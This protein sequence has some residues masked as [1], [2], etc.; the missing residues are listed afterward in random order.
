MVSNIILS[1]IAILS[2]STVSCNAA[3]VGNLKLAPPG[4]EAQGVCTVEEEFGYIDP[5]GLGWMAKAG[6]LTDGASIPPWAQPWVGQ[7]FKPAFIKAAV[8]HDHYCDRHVRP[9]R[10]TH[11]VFYDALLESGVSKGKAGVMYFAILVGGPKWVK[12]IK[13]KPCPFGY[14][15]INS[16]QIGSSL[17]GAGI[18]LGEEDGVLLTRPADFASARFANLMVQH[19]PKLEQK[20]DALDGQEVELQAAKAMAGDLFFSNGEEVGGDLGGR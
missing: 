2:I 8:I 9:W 11:R 13:G 6:L 20:G 17:P 18:S 7:P 16:V 19:L 5:S 1:A 12:L 4:C 3:F 15:C 14:A 10:Q